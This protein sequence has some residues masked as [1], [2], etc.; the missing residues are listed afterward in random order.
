MPADRAA[1]GRSGCRNRK[2]AIAGEAAA[3]R[4]ALWSTVFLPIERLPLVL[5]KV[6]GQDT[7]KGTGDI[8]AHTGPFIPAQT[9]ARLDG[10]LG[11]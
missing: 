8:E 1:P 11:V 9:A 2:A 5:E 7:E 6:H 3:H 4:G 10:I